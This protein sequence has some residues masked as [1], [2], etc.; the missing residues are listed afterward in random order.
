MYKTRNKRSLSTKMLIVFVAASIIPLLILAGISSHYVLKQSEASL[1][2]QIKATSKTMGMLAISHIRAVREYLQGTGL[3]GYVHSDDA[4][5]Y[6]DYSLAEIENVFDPAIARHVI[7]S[8]KDSLHVVNQNLV[9]F[10]PMEDDFWRVSTLDFESW[11]LLKEYVDV[12]QIACLSMQT[13][14]L[15]CTDTLGR[16]TMPLTTTNPVMHS[17]DWYLFLSSIFDTQDGVITLYYSPRLAFSSVSEFLW[18]YPAM[19]LATIL[20]LTVLGMI[21]I[22]RVMQPLKLLTNATSTMTDWDSAIAHPLLQQDNEI[23]AMARSV[24]TMV[25]SEQVLKNELKYQAHYDALTKLR[26]RTTLRDEITRMLSVS[27]ASE[28]EGVSVVFI[29]LNKFKEINDHLGH[30]VGDALLQQVADRLQLLIP[31]DHQLFRFAGDEFVIVSM[32]NDNQVVI[33]NLTFIV[34]QLKKPFYIQP[35]KLEIAGSAGV[36]FYPAHAGNADDLLQYA[37]IAMY[38]AN[39]KAPGDNVCVFEP[40][41][42][43]KAKARAVLTDALRQAIKQ[44]A[45]QLHYQPKIC[46]KTEKIIGAE[47]LIRWIDP[48]LG[49]VPPDVF[50]PLAEESGLIDPISEWVMK[51]ACYQSSKWRLQGINLR[52]AINISGKQFT[53]DLVKQVSRGLLINDLPASALE[54]EITEQCVVDSIETTIETLTGLR[55]LGVHTALDDFGT[56]YSSLSYLREL[57]I[58]TLKIDR[59]FITDFYQSKQKMALVRCIIDVAHALN[60]SV[61]AEGVETAEELHALKEVNAEYIQGYYYSK[62]LPASDFIDFAVENLNATTKSI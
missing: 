42:L 28:D 27:D 51:E 26:N 50:I 38:H 62:P 59:T 41:F 35:H 53:P 1:E 45:F 5:Q 48:H 61:V 22:R 36:A 30:M 49:F 55:K 16:K 57:P 15:F 56:G 33:D 32:M 9:M 40:D 52:V 20:A 7:E 21:M 23:G 13:V 17:S 3:N 25:Q 44:E 24:D 8:R 37:D 34:N 10:L 29:D 43:E 14:T 19:I 6:I 4:I 2:L 11:G 46:A 18:R 12:G 39:D 54:I 47:A 58:D 60:M 31:P